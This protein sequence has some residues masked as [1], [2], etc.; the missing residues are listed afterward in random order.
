MEGGIVRY[1]EK[2][3]DSGLWEGSLY[4][5]DNRKA[6]TFSSNPAVIGQCVLCGAR[7]SRMQNCSSLSCTFESVVCDECSEQEFLC[8][9]DRAKS[10]ARA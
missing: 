7:S 8:E 4:V 5:F 1:G 2:F 10:S 9:E 3:G 6:V